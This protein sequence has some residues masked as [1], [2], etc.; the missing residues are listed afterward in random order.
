MILKQYF[1]IIFT[2]VFLSLPSAFAEGITKH[3]GVIGD[4]CGQCA[5]MCKEPEG[6][7][8]KSL[9]QWICQQCLSL[10]QNKNLG[11]GDNFEYED[12]Y[13]VQPCPAKPIT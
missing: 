3:D 4:D 2:M 12:E 7:S 1:I 8:I 5:E 11:S 9:N 13:E 6:E 10:C